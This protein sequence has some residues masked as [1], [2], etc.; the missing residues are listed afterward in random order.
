MRRKKKIKY[1]C[2][3]ANADVSEKVAIYLKLIKKDAT[4]I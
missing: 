1:I 4:Q 3:G 2:S